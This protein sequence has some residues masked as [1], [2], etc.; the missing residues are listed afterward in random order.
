MKVVTI[1]SIPASI[2]WKY[3]AYL[4]SLLSL[5]GRHD[6]GDDDINSTELSIDD[7]VL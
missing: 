4:T 6:S 1:I 5:A 3:V 2:L 7:T